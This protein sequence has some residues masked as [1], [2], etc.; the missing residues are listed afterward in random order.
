MKSMKIALRY[1]Q[2]SRHDFHTANGIFEDQVE[3]E[4]HTGKINGTL[5][6]ISPIKQVDWRGIFES[7]FKNVKVDADVRTVDQGSVRPS[8]TPASVEP[9]ISPHSKSYMEVM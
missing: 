3:I 6:A 4:T 5:G 2:S 7:N 8:S 9:S 1:I